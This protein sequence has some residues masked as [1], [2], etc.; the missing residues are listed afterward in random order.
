MEF[1][2]L[3]DPQAPASQAFIPG[4]WAW[5]ELIRTMK[6]LSPGGQTDK[7]LERPEVEPCDRRSAHPWNA[8]GAAAEAARACE[9]LAKDC[10]VAM[11]WSW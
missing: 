1:S 11:E 2:L 4:R 7:K 8:R 3:D 10:C 5:Q 9:D 6:E